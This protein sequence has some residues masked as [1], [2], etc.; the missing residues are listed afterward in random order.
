[1]IEWVRDL[2][3]R[4]RTAF[5]AVEDRPSLAWPAAVP[6]LVGLS[7]FVKLGLVVDAIPSF[8]GTLGGPSWGSPSVGKALPPPDRWCS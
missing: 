2:V 8:A 1:M 6:L 4:P 3:V 5:A 7:A